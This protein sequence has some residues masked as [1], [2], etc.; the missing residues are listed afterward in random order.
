MQVTILGLGAMGH[1]MATQ[2]LAHGHDVTVF[3]RSAARAADLE[4]R[5]ARVAETPRLAVEMAEVVVIMVSDDA[6]IQAICEGDEGVLAGLRPG[7]TVLQMSTISPDATDWL[8]RELVVRRVEMLDAPVMGSL[9]EANDGRLWILAGGEQ[10]TIDRV[11]P[12]LG[13]MSQAVYHVGEIG[14]GTL[15]KLCLNLLGGGLVAALAEALALLGAVGID[16]QQYI[17]ILEQTNMP[18]RMVLGKARQMASGDFAPRFS[19][20]NMAKD[21]ALAVSLAR[22]QGLH[23]RQGE[24]TLANLRHSAGV[25]G[26]DRDIAA[27]GA[28]AKVRA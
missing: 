19:L 2:L 4:A 28:G 25:V 9:P 20:D 7:M 3:N 16:E 23:F 21:I 26:G 8:Y 13:A 5:G 6:A 10:Q 27:L 17:T 12:V 22:S 1:G 24:A 11:R 15:I 14:Q 18:A